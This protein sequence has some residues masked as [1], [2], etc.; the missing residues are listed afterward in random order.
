M[1]RKKVNKIVT[2]DHSLYSVYISFKRVISD[3][4]DISSNKYLVMNNKIALKFA[5]N[6]KW[7]VRV[8]LGLENVSL[9][10]AAW[11][12]HTAHQVYEYNYSTC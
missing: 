4:K 5:A 12:S 2:T 10:D 11:N 9:I 7:F 8:F 6:I 3:G 1:G